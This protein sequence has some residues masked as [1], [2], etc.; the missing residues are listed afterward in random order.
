MIVPLTRE[1][2]DQMGYESLS[3]SVRGY[4]D[5]EDGRVLGLCGYYYCGRQIAFAK[6]SDE[7]KRQKFRLMRL[8]YKSIRM[9]NGILIAKCDP[10][11]ENLLR[12]LGFIEGDNT[13][14]RM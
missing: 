6:F 11:G 12:H 9:A 10:G 8:V 4:A 7:L 1:H 14:V 13:W 5:V 2:M 3:Y